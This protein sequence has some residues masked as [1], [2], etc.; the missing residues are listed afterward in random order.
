VRVTVDGTIRVFRL[1]IVERA[2]ILDAARMN[3]GGT[4]RIWGIGAVLL[5][6]RVFSPESHELT[7][8]AFM[9]NPIDKEKEK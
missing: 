6:E 2:V 9:G 8:F 1:P 4:V 3:H 5:L 7:D